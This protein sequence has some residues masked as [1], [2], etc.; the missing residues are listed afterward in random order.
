MFYQ[1]QQLLKPIPGNLGSYAMVYLDSLAGEARALS[2]RYEVHRELTR[3]AV[4]FADKAPAEITTMDVERYLGVRCHGRSA[5]TRK[6]VLAIVSGFFG[7]LVD[8]DAVPKNPT[9]PIRRPSLP[10]AEPT[11]WTAEE[12]RAILAAEMPA[13]DHV[14]LEVLARTGQRVGVVRTLRWGQVH[15]EGKTPSIDFHRGKYG[16]V[17]SIPL[18]REALHD[19]IVLKRLTNPQPDSFVFQSRNRHT[20]GAG[21][22]GLNGPIS[23]LQVNRIIEKACRQ[24]GVR[25]ASAHEFRRSAITNLL[26]AGVAFDIVSRDIAGHASPVTTMKHYRGSESQRVREALRGLPY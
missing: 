12:I 16:R 13:R 25:V 4:E 20:R 14:L 2:T 22:T 17:F 7:Y 26:H 15:L 5:A 23:A 21:A 19:L 3:F 10:E 8:R 11:Y 18:D 1:E 24:A 6:K 9:R